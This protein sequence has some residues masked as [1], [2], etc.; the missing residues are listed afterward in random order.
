MKEALIQLLSC[1]RIEGAGE[2]KRRE[3]M[4]RKHY[5]K[6]DKIETKAFHRNQLFEQI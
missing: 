4:K 6:I 5:F 3:K 1:S 2:M